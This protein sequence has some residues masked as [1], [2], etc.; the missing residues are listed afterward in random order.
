M[1]EMADAFMRQAKEFA[2]ERE[3]QRERARA[4]ATE[5]EAEIGKRIRDAR[6]DTP[7]ASVSE[8]LDYRY[9]LRVPATTLRDVEEGRRPLRLSEAVALAD[10]YG[11]SVL[12][13]AGLGDGTDHAR[14]NELHLLRDYIDGRL[15]ELGQR[16]G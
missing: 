12:H 9:G 11:A 13:F 6:A 1:V 3:A 16:N 7:R 10:L 14:A 4:Y 2:A 15:D 5:R 8:E